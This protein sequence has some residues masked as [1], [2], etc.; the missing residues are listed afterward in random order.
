MNTHSLRALLP[1]A[2]ITATLLAKADDAPATFAVGEFTF[3]RPEAFAWVP[4]EPG[5]RKAQLTVGGAADT[6]I[7]F[8]HFGAGQGGGAQANVTRW[9]ASFEEPKEKLNSKVEETKIK[10]RAVTFVQ[11]EG[12][13]KSGPPMGPKTPK[14]GFMLH[15][16]IVD[17]EQG[18]VFIRFT[19]PAASVKA[20]Q[21]DFRAMVESALK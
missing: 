7:V 4:I 16:A 9:L 11:A 17:S 5:M 15:G 3:K 19:G 2:L 13:Y 18:S 6:E 8:F 1:L 20:R 14:P 12:T 21:A 10:D